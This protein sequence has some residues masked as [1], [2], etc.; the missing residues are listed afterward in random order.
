VKW[1][2]R[3]GGHLMGTFRV[4]VHVPKEMVDFLQEHCDD[5]TQKTALEWIRSHWHALAEGYDALM[6][7]DG[8]PEIVQEQEI[9]QAKADGYLPY[10]GPEIITS[11]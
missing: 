7:V 10:E 3:K 4:R 1:T 11:T 8:D 2:I 9:D 6:V 5:L